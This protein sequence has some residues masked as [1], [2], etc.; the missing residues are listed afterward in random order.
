MNDRGQLVLIASLVIT[1][2][3][4]PMAFAYLQLGYDA[5]VETSIDATNPEDDAHRVLVRA[6][7]NASSSIPER[8]SWTNRTDAAHSLRSTLSSRVETIETGLLEQGIAREITY[9]DTAAMAWAN[10]SCPSGPARQ[11]GPCDVDRGVVVQE[12]AGRS[13]VLRVAVDLETTTD[14]RQSS[15]TWVVDAW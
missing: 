6:V 8:F 7:H 12:R 3:I 1:V 2:A 5:D 15:V 13:H 4:V 11:F 14:R 9:N 10:G